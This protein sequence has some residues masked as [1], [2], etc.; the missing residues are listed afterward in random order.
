MYTNG[1]GTDAAGAFINYMMGDK[2][3]DSIES[4]GYGVSSK[5]SDEA[6]ASHN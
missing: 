5:M 1:N 6:V 4:M 3:A 2:F